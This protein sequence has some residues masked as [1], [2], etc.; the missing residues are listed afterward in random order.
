MQKGESAV[1]EKGLK[2]NLSWTAAG[3][4]LYNLAIWLLSALTLRMLGATMS[5]Y[6]AVAASIGN[7]LYAVALWGMRSFIVSDQRKEFSLEEYLGAR[8]AAISIGAAVLVIILLA[9]HYD[10][11]QIVILILYSGFK[12]TEAL[13]EVLD[14][15]MQQRK[16]MEINARSM[17]LRS[18][19]FMAGFYAILAATHSLA[20]GLA[21][22]LLCSL[23]VFFLYN[24]RSVRAAASLGTP[25]FSG[26]TALIIRDCLP[27]MLFEMLA[28][29]VVAIP[30]LRF[31]A[32][33][34][35]DALG[36][37][38]SIYTMVVFMQLA[39]NIF[40][41]TFAPYMAEAWQKPGHAGFRKYLLMLFGGSAGLGLLAE[42]MVL[43]LGRPVIGLLFGQQ[44]APYYSYLYIG[45]ISGVTLAWTWIFSQLFTIL[46][47]MADLLI[48]S[49]VST[50]ACV[51]L[52]NL[53]V[54]A[55]D[56]NSMSLALIGTNLVFI[57]AASA[58]LALHRKERTE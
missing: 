32:I 36:I 23:A 43:L 35:L 42:L 49:A 31:Q 26:R 16:Q 29:A 20:A 24:L 56:C 54:T 58:M 21:G 8:L 50:A 2:K 51:L 18:V 45:I 19:L 38:T 46:R 11:M 5:G 9:S 37:Y 1:A 27:I 12:F 55:S 34:S 47:R 40:I 28:A 44:A 7:T 25:A 53:L 41:Y 6:Y 30:R 10:S 57:I 4:V 3:M 22:I 39:I 52:S 13:I 17:I 33:G 48:C 15:F 14:C